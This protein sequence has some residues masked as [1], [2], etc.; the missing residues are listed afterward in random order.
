MPTTSIKFTSKLPATSTTIFSVM[1]Q[2]AAEHN[3][4]NLGQ[5]FPGFDIDPALIES[6]H[7]AMKGGFNQYAPMPGILSLRELLSDKMKEAYGTFYNPSDEITITAGGTQAIYSVISALIKSGDEVI[8][9]APAYDCYAPAVE[10]NGGKVVW[11]ET[12]YP[13]YK[14]DWSQVKNAISEKTRLIVVNTPQNPSSAVWSKDDLETLSSLVQN[15]DIIILSD[16]VYEHILFDGLKHQSCASVAGLAERSIL[17]YSFGKTLHVTGW[18]LG[19]VVGPKELMSEFRKVHQYNV[20]SCNTPMQVAIEAYMKNA[21]VYTSLP[22]FYQEKRDRF[23]SKITNEKFDI[24]PAKGSYFQVMKFKANMGK[25][26][27][28][29]AKEWTIQGGITTIPLSVFYPVERNEAVFRFCFAKS[30]EVLDKAAEKI[31]Q[32]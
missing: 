24:R 28:E 30:D 16:E 14:V 8:L 31:N 26:D 15:T 2:L 11:I 25:S 21:S 27:V 12:F 22:S 4:I 20:F 19:Y 17:V 9:F 1:S 6:V 5:G 7:Q 3:A 10:L 13:D 32:L 18:K 23:L 29:T